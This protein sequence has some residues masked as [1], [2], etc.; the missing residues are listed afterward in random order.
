M[1]RWLTFIAIIFAMQF[2][3]A[4]SGYKLVNKIS[5]HGDGKWDYLKAD[6]KANRL[7]VS[8]FDRVHV[9]DTRSETEIKTIGNLNGV[10]G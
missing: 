1:K 8:H 10:H 9:I 4:Q 3:K 6:E 7:F 2:T 5:L